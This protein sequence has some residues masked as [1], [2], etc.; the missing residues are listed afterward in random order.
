MTGISTRQV[1]MD[2]TALLDCFSLSCLEKQYKKIANSIG[3]RKG[4]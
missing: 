2:G 4:E 1:K 3:K